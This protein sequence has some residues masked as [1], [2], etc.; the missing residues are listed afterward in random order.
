MMIRDSLVVPAHEGHAHAVAFSPDGAWLASAGADGTIRLWQVPGFEPGPT[1]IGHQRAASSVAFAPSGKRM[2]TGSSDDTVRIWSVPDGAQLHRLDA[3]R[4]P[5]YSR[6]GKLLTTIAESGQITH[7]DATSHEKLSEL[8]AVDRRVI[9]FDFAP[10]ETELLVGGTGTIHRVRLHDGRSLGTLT[11]HGVAVQ[12]LAVS[13]DGLTLASTG[14]EGTLR[15]WDT[16]SWQVLQEVPLHTGGQ[17]A[18]A[19]SPAGDRVAV[20]GDHVV[21]LVPLLPGQPARRLEVA[22]KG[23]YGVSFSP[24][25]RWLANAG[26]DGK[27]RIW[28]LTD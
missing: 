9:C 1:L 4:L 5:R 25:G 24:D 11:G 12:G 17:L 18:L 23:L 10:R 19:W 26:A 16:G 8:P 20:A 7:W 13:P 21:Q 6:D 22:I 2:A 14:A 15:F 27:L 3:Q 28:D